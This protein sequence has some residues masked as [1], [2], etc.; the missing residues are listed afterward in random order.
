[1]YAEL[2][3]TRPG[4]IQILLICR[5]IYEEALPYL[6]KRTLNFLSQLSLFNWIEKAD[7]RYLHYVKAISLQLEDVDMSQMIYRVLPTP[8]LTAWSL[9]DREANKILLTLKKLPN[10]CDITISQ[11]F[12][13]TTQSQIYKRFVYHL[14]EA[15]GVRVPMLRRL[16][17]ADDL[18][19]IFSFKALSFMSSLES[20]C[21][22][23]YG[24]LNS[25]DTAEALRGLS[26]L[27]KLEIGPPAFEPHTRPL[28][29]PDLQHSIPIPIACTVIAM[30]GPLTS[31]SLTERR[32]PIGLPTILTAL[33]LYQMQTL[34]TFT[35]SLRNPPGDE[36]SAVIFGLLGRS[37]IKHAELRWPQLSPCYAGD[38]PPTSLPA[39][40]RSLSMSI[41]CDQDALEFL[42]WILVCKQGRLL[43]HFHDIAIEVDPVSL[44]QFVIRPTVSLVPAM[45]LIAP[46]AHQR[47]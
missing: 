23:G 7:K 9:Y 3:L 44:G 24:C 16:A 20:L 34:Q 1:M 12:F 21:L 43:R 36:L 6:Y 35:I 39:S 38:S 25:N 17:L 19:S 37:C 28:Q 2:F 13:H 30:A 18:S 27:T 42:E 10:L 8:N 26:R 45:Y 31:F 11:P 22:S 46:R 47:L 32:H 5:K 40:L 15:I 33:E 29:R 14:I 4:N 41:S